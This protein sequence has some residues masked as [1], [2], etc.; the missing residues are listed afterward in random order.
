MQRACSILSSVACQALHYISALSHKWR[1]SRKSVIEH[2]M[3]ILIF[4]TTTV[5]NIS[6]SKKNWA[7]YDQKCILVF[8]KIDR[9]SRQIWIKLKFSEQIFWEVPKYKISWK[10][11]QWGTE[12]FH[13]DGRTD[14]RT[15][16]TKAVVAFRSFANARKSWRHRRV[17]TATVVTSRRHDVTM[18]L[19]CL[20][21]NSRIFWVK[22]KVPLWGRPALQPYRLI[23]HWPPKEFLH[24]SLEALHT[25]RRE[26]HQLAKE[27]TIDGI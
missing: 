23:V 21:R 10:S 7:R 5:W 2:N 13:A 25:K 26:R 15:D 8:M 11:V 24:S 14:G 27:G 9:Y 3:C 6:H 20:L 1:D 22:G 18:Y 16:T 19:H 17:S 4:S 12:L